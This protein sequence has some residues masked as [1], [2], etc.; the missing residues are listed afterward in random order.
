MIIWSYNLLWLGL[1]SIGWVIQLTSER[2]LD[3]R[4]LMYKNFITDNFDFLKLLT[5]FLQNSL[6]AYKICFFELGN[7][8]YWGIWEDQTT[9]SNSNNKWL[10]CPIYF[11]YSIL[12]MVR[13][14]MFI[15][16]NGNQ[17]TG[18]ICF[19]QATVSYMDKFY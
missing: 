15:E 17:F 19:N 5:L 4:K 10:F 1:I 13:N 6:L 18:A 14:Y 9:N 7:Y 2:K 12:F 8:D 16:S 3:L 11:T